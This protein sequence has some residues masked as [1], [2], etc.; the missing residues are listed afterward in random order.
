MS[1]ATQFIG[2]VHADSPM[3]PYEQWYSEKPDLEKYPM[4]PFDTII[5]AHIPICKQ[6]VGTPPS[7]LTY[8][9]GTALLQKKLKII[10]A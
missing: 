1:Y 9:V 8:A 3:S 10:Q 5:M 7:E 4:L 6:S 2:S